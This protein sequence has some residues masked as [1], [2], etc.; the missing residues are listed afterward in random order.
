MWGG[1]R[2]IDIWFNL[3]RY[4]GGGGRKIYIIIYILPIYIYIYIIRGGR[5]IYN[6]SNIII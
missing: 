1:G 5:K 2:K 4:D 3:N 6:I